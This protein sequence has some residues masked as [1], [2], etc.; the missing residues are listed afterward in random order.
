MLFRSDH[1]TE[2]RDGLAIGQSIEP[3]VEQRLQP[4]W[5]ILSTVI[6]RAVC[7]FQHRSRQL[8]DEQRHAIGFYRTH[9][10]AEE[11]EEFLE[12]GIVH[13]LM[14]LLLRA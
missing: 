7:S 5:H 11:G 14:R 12:A 6:G 10:F 13:R 4:A 3:R 2:L 9:R 1:C 8:F